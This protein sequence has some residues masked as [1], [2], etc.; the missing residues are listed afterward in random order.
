MSRDLGV[1]ATAAISSGEVAP[2]IACYLDFENDP[3]YAWTGTSD[4]D[5]QGET[6]KGLHNA[7]SFDFIQETSDIRIS[8]VNLTLSKVPNEI[9]GDVSAYNYKDRE[10]R[11][12]MVLLDPDD[13]AGDPLLWLTIFHGDMD[14]LAADVQPASSTIELTVINRLARL[15]HSWG[16]LYSDAD[17][18]QLF[19]GDTSMRFMQDLQDVKIEL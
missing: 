9:L 15:K 16:E 4:I 3:V 10:A 8:N 11:L 13:M 7:A 2:A 19:P 12:F 6:W 17:Q 14:Q 18:Q 5:A 1:S